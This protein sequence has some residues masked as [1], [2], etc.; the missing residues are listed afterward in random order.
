[1]S[2]GGIEKNVDGCCAAQ[3][4]AVNVGANVSVF[5]TLPDEQVFVSDIGLS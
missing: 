2:K 5:M 3:A 4:C 1:M